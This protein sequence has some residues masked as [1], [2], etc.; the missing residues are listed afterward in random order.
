[1]SSLYNA[2]SEDG[3]LVSQVGDATTMRDPDDSQSY[4]RNRFLLERCLADVGFES[5]KHYDGVGAVEP[6]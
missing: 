3:I 2:L 5:I 1:M 4:H 6:I